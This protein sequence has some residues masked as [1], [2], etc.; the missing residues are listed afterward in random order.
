MI[1]DV[2]LFFSPSKLENKWFSQMMKITALPVA[3]LETN[4]KLEVSRKPSIRIYYC[5]FYTFKRRGKKTD[6]TNLR[7][8]PRGMLKRWN[9][10]PGKKHINYHLEKPIHCDG[11]KTSWVGLYPTTGTLWEEFLNYCRWSMITSRQKN[12]HGVV[13]TTVK[14]YLKCQ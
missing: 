11:S 10:Y 14:F 7:K 4:L 2:F 12:K 5:C 9:N 1:E 3:S 6:A 8:P 13:L